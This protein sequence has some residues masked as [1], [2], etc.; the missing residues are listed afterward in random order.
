MYKERLD[1][2]ELL[3]P[4]NRCS[5]SKEEL[6]NMFFCLKCG[7][8]LYKY[9]NNQEI[10][11]NLKKDYILDKKFIN[12]L[13]EIYKDQIMEDLDWMIF[14]GYYMDCPICKNNF[15]S[16]EGLIENFCFTPIGMLLLIKNNFFI[17]NKKEKKL[18]EKD[19]ENKFVLTLKKSF[20]QQVKTSINCFIDV[21]TDDYIYEI[22][23]NP[24]MEDLHLAYGQLKHYQ[25]DYPNRKLAIIANKF[26]KN[27]LN[28]EVELIIFN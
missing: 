5:F 17:V 6:Y 18:C 20:K 12:E 1:F 4:K 2:L 27:Y 8:N 24:R 23:L 7:S 26:P 11:N 10:L 15:Y 13:N 3:F 21:L 28:K 19:I 25:Q 14:E 16:E 9:F 22:K